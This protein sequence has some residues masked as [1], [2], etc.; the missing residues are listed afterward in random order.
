MMRPKPS[1]KKTQSHQKFLGVRFD[2]CHA[3]GR[4]YLNDAGDAY[5]GRCPRCGTPYHVWVGEGGTDS[6][7]FLASCP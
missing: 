6:R 7:M 1:F 3:Y 5:V 2:N 4:L